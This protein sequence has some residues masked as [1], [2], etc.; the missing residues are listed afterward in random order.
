MRCLGWIAVAAIGLLA[1][2][3]RAR[4]GP[5]TL[6]GDLT[7]AC[8]PRIDTDRVAERDRSRA[9]LARAQ[10]GLLQA[11]ETYL[12]QVRLRRLSAKLK[13]LEGE[14]FVCVPGRVAAVRLDAEAQRVTLAVG[15]RQ[16]VMVRALAVDFRG[17][18]GLVTD[19]DDDFCEVMLLTDPVSAVP[20]A[21]V[22]P[23]DPSS[24]KAGSQEPA[25]KTAPTASGAVLGG[26]SVNGEPSGLLRLTYLDN[27]EALEIG[28]ELVTSGQGDVYPQGL[29]VG[30]I[31]GHP[32]TAERLAPA[33]ADV[34]PFVNWPS[35]CELIVAWRPPR[36]ERPHE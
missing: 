33:H 1:Y 14:G 9:E 3:G 28:Q 4:G 27:E 16:G 34:L 10:F 5:P 20:V 2:V 18:A 30:C 22:A 31:V 24:G 26:R 36:A 12:S 21:T 7:R 13:D 23:P 19:V 32:V 11:T 35:L 29:P 6:D 8:L 17:L 15:R 25:G